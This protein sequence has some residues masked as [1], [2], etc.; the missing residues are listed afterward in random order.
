MDATASNWHS[1]IEA[2]RVLNNPQEITWHGEADIIVVGF[3]GSG[4]AMALQANELGQSVIALDR[5][6]G[7][8][9]TVAS[10][11][12]IYAGGGTPLQQAAGV[13]DDFENMFAYMRQETA[14]VVSDKTLLR[15]CTESPATIR[16]LSDHGVQFRSTLW[17]GKTS[18]P[19]V[20]Y[21]L[22]HADSSLAASYK[23]VA[24]PA[25]RG[26]RGYVPPELGIKARNL[27]G[28]IYAPLRSAAV[29][30]GTVV[31]EQAEVR[32]LITDRNGRVIG[33]RVLQFDA[34]SAAARRHQALLRRG[35]SLLANYPANFPLG[36][37]VKRA[38]RHYL[39]QARG[40]EAT[41]RVERFYRAH[42]AVG[43]CTGGFIF[44]QEMLEHY[45]A[46][47][48]RGFPIGTQG[49]DGAG[50][51]L[52][53]TV[54]GAVAHMDRVS[55]WRF[56]NPPLAWSQGIVVN[57]RG[58]RFVDETVYGAKLGAEIGERQNGEAFLIFDA[59]LAAA[60]LAQVAEQ[61]ILPFQRDLARLN[62]W[63]AAKSASSLLGLARKI[64]VAASG[65]LATVERYNQ[66]ALGRLLDPFGKATE[67]MQ[68]LLQGPYYAIDIGLGA[69]LFPCPT[70]TLGG[71]AVD[72]DSG[73]VKHVD[74]SLIPSLY[75]AGRNAVGICSGNYVSGLS[76]GDCIFSGRRA[77]RHAAQQ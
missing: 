53:Q 36:T 76:I 13:D 28:S 7:G 56:I 9:A 40:L 20:E 29:R 31:H 44:N 63:V 39:D 42:K 60:A 4:A 46:R 3:G 32:Q 14:G 23:K 30:L 21:F 47:Y 26:H 12:V 37:W 45:A 33:V 75:A 52:G 62:M 15:Y 25:A 35:Q 70:L 38:A 43:L 69:R 6:Q 17:P 58:E 49:D 55:A 22:Y 41:E 73:Q 1:S 65:L 71:L 19:P 11:G 48:A 59:R 66:S 8:G 54:G 68:G 57:R 51:R 5:F 2:V 10:G 16:W 77:A 64:G 24:R 18:Y 74:G 27:G 61:K 72:E 67:D 34:H 50:I